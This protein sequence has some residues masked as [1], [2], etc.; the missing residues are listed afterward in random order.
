MTDLKK[1]IYLGDNVGN[2]IHFYL[3]GTDLTGDILEQGCLISEIS[4]YISAVQL[5][6]WKKKIKIQL[7]LSFQA[8]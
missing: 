3:K 1:A 6:R 7:H 2:V 5:P 4:F 8:V